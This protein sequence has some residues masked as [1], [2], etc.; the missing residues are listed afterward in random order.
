MRFLTR[1]L[2]HQTIGL[3]TRY[4]NQLSE[5][6][7][8]IHR[9][10]KPFQ[11][12]YENGMKRRDLLTNS[13]L[14]V[15]VLRNGTFV[16]VDFDMYRRDDLFLCIWYA[17]DFFFWLKSVHEWIC[18]PASPA[19]YLINVDEK[20]RCMQ[21]KRLQQTHERLKKKRKWMP[22]KKKLLDVSFVGML[23]RP[24]IEPGSRPWQG[25]ILPLDQRC[26]RL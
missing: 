12:E 13:S 22:A 18:K 7:E 8:S 25:R 6:L 19:E 2:Q 1:G 15:H 20:S 17:E 23:H 10:S 26:E 4:K 5:W 14:R 9:K 3:C 21:E 11:W 24:G 16:R